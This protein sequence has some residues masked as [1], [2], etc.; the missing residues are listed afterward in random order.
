[1]TEVGV[2]QAPATLSAPITN[3][4]TTAVL[5]SSSN[6]WPGESNGPAFANMRATITD[7]T[8]YE[9]VLV[10][11]NDGAGNVTIQRAVEPTNR[12]VQTAFGFAAGSTIAPTFT[13]GG[14]NVGAVALP[15][16]FQS[17]DG[18][19][20]TA[21]PTTPNTVGGLYFDTSGASGLWAA[22]AATS[23]DWLPLGAISGTGG[24]TYVTDGAGF[25]SVFL[26]A[27]GDS[28]DANLVSSAGAKIRTINSATIVDSP[29]GTNAWNFSDDGGMQFGSDAVTLY[30][31]G[32]V[33][34]LP[35]S[36]NTPALGICGDGTFAFNTG[37]DWTATMSF[38][39]VI[40]PVQATTA[41]APAW[42]VGGM[43]FDTTLN[44]L[45]IGGASGWETVTSS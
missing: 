14:A 16:W 11:A 37:G 10:T 43:Y 27:L 4:A 26:T 6:G 24:L 39:G 5:A 38:A 2:N 13:F 12:G 34:G 29:G 20:V 41:S 15:A 28:E 40:F 33:A 31:A 25:A 1:M 32:D 22:A 45:R 3:I 17:G 36:P 7:G 19:P 9:I 44:K 18:D 35:A 21:N 30:T 8:H 23:A 42:V